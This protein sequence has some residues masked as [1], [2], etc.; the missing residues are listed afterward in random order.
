MLKA[1][2]SFL[3]RCFLQTL[4]IWTTLTN[5]SSK[6]LGLWQ[7]REHSGWSGSNRMI[8]LRLVGLRRNENT[9]MILDFNR[10]ELR[11]YMISSDGLGSN[12]ATTLRQFRLQQA[13][14]TSTVCSNRT[15]PCVPLKSIHLG[16]SE[17]IPTVYLSWSTI[18]IHL[19]SF[20]C[21]IQQKGMTG[22]PPPRYHLEIWS[23]SIL[24]WSTMNLLS[25]EY[26]VPPWLQAYNS[27]DLSLTCMHSFKLT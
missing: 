12:L 19:P 22:S 10:F 14:T 6:K 16:H 9:P 21:D 24:M 23:S 27:L 5:S 25:L 7:H 13:R 1:S 26:E 4:M 8:S 20:R 15:P 18:M 3:S 2:D 17:Y 11:Q